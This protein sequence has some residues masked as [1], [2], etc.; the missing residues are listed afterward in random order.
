MIQ[1]LGAYISHTTNTS[2]KTGVLYEA[3]GIPYTM[4]AMLHL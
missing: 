3:G 1:T 2:H 4:T